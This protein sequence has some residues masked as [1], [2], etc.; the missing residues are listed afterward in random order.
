[1]EEK[2]NYQLLISTCPSLEIADKLAH[3]LL[4][5]RLAACV[6]IIPKVHS[7]FEWQGQITTED[8]VLLFIKTH[9]RHYLAIEQTLQQQH[10]YTVPELIAV[11]ITAG[12]TAYLNWIDST[13]S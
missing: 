6:N 7:V 5:K 4:K 13:V 3:S 12:L 9:R 10:P 2:S 1:M 11:P 8:E